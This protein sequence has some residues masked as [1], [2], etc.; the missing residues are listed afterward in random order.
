MK[1]SP[2]AE[3]CCFISFA[4]FLIPYF[5]HAFNQTDMD[6]LQSTRECQWCDLRGADLT[7]ANL[8][9]A[10]LSGANLSRAKLSQADLTGANLSTAYLHGAN[11]TR[12]N[13]TN[14]YLSKANLSGAEILDATM[15]G[16][17]L[18]GATWVDGRKCEQGSMGE[19]KAAEGIPA[20]VGESSF[21]P[22]SGQPR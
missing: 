1:K 16:A 4:V 5:S 18:T 21:S 3:I 11:L 7:G 17:N 10:N 2:G 19:C 8:S 9:G 15:N 12:A 22:R 13:L 6:K 14:A 20:N